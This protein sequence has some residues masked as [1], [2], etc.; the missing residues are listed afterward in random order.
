MRSDTKYIVL[1]IMNYFDFSL[2]KI[3]S[4]TGSSLKNGLNA[5]KVAENR[6]NFGSNA[7]PKKRKTSFI[8]RLF[9]CL[10]EPTLVILE[11]AW[12][13]TVGVNIGKFLRTGDGDI[14]ECVGI[15]IAIALSVGL[16]MIMEGKSEKAF[17]LLGKEYDKVSVKVVRGGEI[18]VIPKEEIVVGDVVIIETGD[19]IIADGRLIESRGLTV[20]E[21][22][23]TGESLPVGK[24]ADAKVKENAAL[25][26]RFNV[27]YSGTFV[28]GGTGKMIVTAVGANAELGKIASDLTLESAVSAP[29]SEKLTRLGKTVT[30]VGSIAASLAFILSVVKLVITDNVNFVSVQD[31]FIE[32]IVLIVA[33]VPEGL[34][35]TAAI[36]LTL[37]V[38][39]LAK[40][41][42]LIRKL[43]RRNK[44]RRRQT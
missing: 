12:I 16:T 24:N 35:T 31:C 2:Q 30:I 22:T 8:K 37:N 15:F 29:L 4:L 3:E 10:A 23:L 44:N 17:E 27:A 5:E 14:Y 13:I 7:L 28:C 26:E 36:S 20:D 6:K 18:I 34:P 1:V 39:K 42:A 19:K 43:Y 41:N 38:L 33:A 40:S 32:A 25:A 21:S 9:S 11:F